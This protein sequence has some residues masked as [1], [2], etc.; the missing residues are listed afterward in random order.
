MM[1]LVRVKALIVEF[2][3]SLPTRDATQDIKPAYRANGRIQI[4]KM[5]HASRLMHCGPVGPSVHV[6]P[7]AQTMKWLW[8][9]DAA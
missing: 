4:T 7:G 3:P 6:D 2:E 5:S 1:L 8:E 9:N